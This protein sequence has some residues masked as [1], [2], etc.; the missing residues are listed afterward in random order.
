M[1]PWSYLNP[2]PPFCTNLL[3][4]FC[5]SSILPDDESLMM[6]PS[7]TIDTFWQMTYPLSTTVHTDIITCWQDGA[8]AFSPVV[9]KLLQLLVGVRVE[10]LWNFE[11]KGQGQR[12]H[13]YLSPGKK[14]SWSSNWSGRGNSMTSNIHV[15][16]G[17]RV[18]LW[19]FDHSNY[20]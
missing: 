17:Q 2:I 15:F 12:R 11:V 5:K 3:Q 6:H 9:I 18:I 4:T 16:Q 19:C 1:N 20:H 8:F 13:L 7:N 14:D 10:S